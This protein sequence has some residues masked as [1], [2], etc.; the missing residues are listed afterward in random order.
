MPIIFQI[1]ISSIS[2]LPGTIS[3]AAGESSLGTTTTCVPG[4]VNNYLLFF[5]LRGKFPTF[6][7]YA[8]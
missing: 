7:I 4:G 5:L 8:I 3:I 6:G 1:L 2:P